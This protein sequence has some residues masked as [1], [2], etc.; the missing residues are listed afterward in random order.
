M[1]LQSLKF[2]REIGP[3]RQN[4]L[5][6]CLLENVR[7]DSVRFSHLVERLL[8]FS[9][10]HFRQLFVILQILLFDLLGRHVQL[11]SSIRVPLVE[12]V[13]ILIVLFDISCAHRLFVF[14]RRQIVQQ[15]FGFN[16]WLKLSS[17]RVHSDV[18]HSFLRS[19]YDI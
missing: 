10:S 12:S 17:F 7:L 2:S 8:Y 19:K 3:I 15:H 6:N 1:T 5:L 16:C 9:L 11:F 14:V 13:R 18:S 4:M